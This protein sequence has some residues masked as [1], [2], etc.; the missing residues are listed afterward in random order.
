MHTLQF[1]KTLAGKRTCFHPGASGLAPNVIPG[2]EPK[3]TGWE[4]VKKMLGYVWPKD[5]PSI[6]ARVMVAVSLLVGAKVCI[7]LTAGSPVRTFKTMY[8]GLKCSPQT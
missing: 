6:K 8:F 3:I 1:Q 2:S 4:I 7:L 5:K